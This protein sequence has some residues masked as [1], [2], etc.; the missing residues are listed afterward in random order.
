MICA[1][2]LAAG[3]SR[4]MGTQKLLL[5]FAGST[6]IA[7]VV[8]QIIASDVQRVRVVVGG[9]QAAIAGCL[10]GRSV[11]IVPNPEPDSEM[12]ASVRCGLRGLPPACRG[13]LVA[14]GDQ[15][16]L[17]TELVNALVKAFDAADRGIVVPVH[18]G[19]RG[20]PLLFALDY[21]ERIMTDYDEVGLRGLLWDH[22]ADVLE[23]PV[24]WPAA[25]SDMDRPEDYR[26]EL[27]RLDGDGA[28]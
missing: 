7:R 20:H 4:R 21:R 8:D 18:D 11:E 3:R 26:R 27:E 16:G 25:I 22:A 6:V 24:P 2:V 12:L 13:V 5:P 19:R 10:S 23:V 9:D 15:P 14:L 1:V 17:T 28:G